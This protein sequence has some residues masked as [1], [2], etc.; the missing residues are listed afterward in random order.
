[1]GW[2]SMCISNLRYS[3]L[4]P[5]FDSIQNSNIRSNTNEHRLNI[6]LHVLLRQIGPGQSFTFWLNYENDNIQLPNYSWHILLYRYTHTRLQNKITNISETNELLTL[7][8]ALST[9]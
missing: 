5:L 6:F 9:T 7:Q 1:M 3:R 2:N 8:Q 4:F